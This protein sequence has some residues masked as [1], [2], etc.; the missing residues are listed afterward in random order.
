MPTHYLA[1]QR[2]CALVVGIDKYRHHS[3][4]HNAVSDAR[5]VG[6]KLESKGATVVYAID[7]TIS[8]LKTKIEE[9]LKLLQEDDV[10]ML[11]FAGHGCE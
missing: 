5:A 9:Y 10:A 4:L 2:I 8:E 11:Y 6:S 1:T 7:C 3:P